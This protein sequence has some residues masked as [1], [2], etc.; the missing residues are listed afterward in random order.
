MSGTETGGKEG[1]LTLVG[2]ARAGRCWSKVIRREWGWMEVWKEAGVS[3][4]GE[5][6]LG[7][8]SSGP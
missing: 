3:L 2:N 7:F 4:Y 8:L 5:E 6:L 1:R